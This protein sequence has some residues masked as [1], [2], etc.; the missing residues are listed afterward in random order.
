MQFFFWL[1][2]CSPFSRIFVERPAVSCLGSC[3][4]IFAS[5]SNGPLPAACNT[6]KNPVSSKLVVFKTKKDHASR[7]SVCKDSFQRTKKCPF[8]LEAL[9]VLVTCQG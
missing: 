5:S 2:A 7:V 3:Y 8:V 1:A 4:F 9:L 6:K